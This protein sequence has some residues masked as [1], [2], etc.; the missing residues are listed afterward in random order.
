[1]T[2]SGEETIGLLVEPIL[3]LSNPWVSIVPL[4]DDLEVVLITT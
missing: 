3:D 4:E 1:M 2:T